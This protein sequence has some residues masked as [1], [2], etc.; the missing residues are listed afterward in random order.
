MQ[1]LKPKLDV[2]FKMIFGDERNT[3]IIIAFI[4]ALLDLPKENINKISILNAEVPEEEYDLKFSRLDLRMDINNSGENEIV[5]IEIQILSEPNY[6]DRSLLYWSKNFNTQLKTG[7]PYSKLK[8]T[9]CLN[10]INF[11]L[12]K[13]DIYHSAF[14]LMEKERHEILTDKI[15]IHFFELKKLKKFLNEQGENHKT[16]P[17]ENW[18][19]F[20][21]VETEDDIMLLEKNL[22]EEDQVLN[23]AI[24]VLK[25]ISSDEKAKQ[26]AELREKRLHDEAT[27][28]EAAEV[29]GKLSAF[30]SL[31]KDGILKSSDAAKRLNISEERFLAKMKEAELL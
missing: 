26:I 7:E 18:L 17:M 13:S 11:D 20:V 9:V 14:T 22:H 6:Q 16:S 25:R 8:R 21:N 23:N 12:F 5:N 19:S 2:I 15:E 29:R 24:V 30:I 10:I 31:V 27:A 4:A 1:I 28:L 3:E